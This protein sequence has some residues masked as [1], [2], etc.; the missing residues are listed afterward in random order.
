M[1]A[2][3]RLLF[4]YVTLMCQYGVDSRQAYEFRLWHSTDREFAS[5]ADTARLVWQAMESH[6]TGKD[7]AE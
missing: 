4:E 7:G 1:T 6:E 2:T 3:R 5:L